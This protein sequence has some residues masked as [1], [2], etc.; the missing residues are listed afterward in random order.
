MSRTSVATRHGLVM[1]PF[2]HAPAWDD[3]SAMKAKRRLWHFLVAVA[4]KLQG[5]KGNSFEE[6]YR[7]C[8]NL[9]LH[10]Y[11][12]DCETLLKLAINI[13]VRTYKSQ[14]DLALGATKLNDLYLYYNRTVAKSMGLKTAEQLVETAVKQK[15]HQEMVA[16]ARR[17][18]RRARWQK[19]W[20]EYY[21]APTGL[22]GT[23]M[24][25]RKEDWES[26]AS[27]KRTLAQE[28][29]DE[30]QTPAKRTRAI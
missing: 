8:Y 6:A 23:F 9:V 24:A 10:R 18:E 16:Y 29:D 21:W 26:L 12:K 15:E 11:R 19:I 20:D 22:P 14:S 5:A 25:Q 27:G 1:K 7:M 28:E 2:P 13:L 30:E 4:T 3:E 17:L